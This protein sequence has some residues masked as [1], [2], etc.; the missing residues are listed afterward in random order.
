MRRLLCIPILLAAACLRAQ[1]VEGSVFDAST[2]AAASGVKVELLKGATP[3]YETT[4]DG[5][6]RF[7][8]D[9]VREG[10]FAVRY[11]SPDYWL[12]AGP[13]DYRTFHVAAGT[14]V[15]LE[16][17]LMPWSKISG[18]VVDRR[19]NG[20]PKAQVTVT[21][22]GMTVN[23]RIYLRTSWGGGG[24]GALSA[25]PMPLGMMGTTDAEGK[26]EVQL[27]PGSYELA[28]TPPPDLTPPASDPDGPALVWKRT[29]YPG[30]TAAEAATR[31]VVLPG[32]EFSNFELKLAAV[33][34]R[35]VRGLLLLPDGA[36]AGKVQVSI[37]EM[38]RAIPVETKSDGSFEFPAVAEGEYRVFAELQQ[39]STKLRV[40]DW[41]EVSRHDVENLKLRLTPSITV[42]EKVIMDADK[43]AP[44]MRPGPIILSLRGGRAAGEM[45][46]PAELIN[47]TKDEFIVRDLY[48]GTYRVAQMLQQPSPPYYLDS[49]RA[50]D[51]DLLTQDVQL[52]S[53]TP[54]TVTYR[55]D[56]GS[57]HG[58]AEKC[59]S[60]GVLLVPQDASLRSAGFS[61]SAPCDA[62]GYYEVRAVRPGEYYALALAG[63]GPV[64]AVDDALLNRAVKVTVR[65]GEVT[66]TDLK[67]VTKPVY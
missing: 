44:R 12:T 67:A 26:F 17:R 8:F 63:N 53:E 25:S 18:R 35:V 31:I 24:G 27:M 40:V 49:V 47:G 46:A 30:V 62:S 50:G 56:G 10:D 39:G 14:P 37:G 29:Y 65:A 61:K 13:S 16:M 57:V 55:T 60:G 43:D 28:V 48:P 41:V 7:R 6:G 21:G 5:G 52:S 34:A 3:F 42:R 36:P 19:G 66:S 11:Q 58:T 1:T 38:F 23:G 33:P 20:V 22:S 59:A 15:K 9:D 32:G 51:A 45:M 4:T 64:P 54:I 2:G